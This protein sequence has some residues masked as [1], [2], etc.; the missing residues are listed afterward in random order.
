M[1][2]EGRDGLFV[3]VNDPTKLS[4]LLTRLTRVAGYVRVGPENKALF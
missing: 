2:S 1:T 4:G 3:A